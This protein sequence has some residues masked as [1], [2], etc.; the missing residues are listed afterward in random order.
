M[1]VRKEAKDAFINPSSLYS[2][3]R[4]ELSALKLF[5]LG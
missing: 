5:Y 1:L 2:G 3:P 4:G